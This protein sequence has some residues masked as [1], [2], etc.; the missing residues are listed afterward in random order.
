MDLMEC[1]A[2]FCG[3]DDPVTL[4]EGCCPVCP[5]GLPWSDWLISLLHDDI[6]EP[7]N[8]TD[9][10][11]LHNETWAT[12]DCEQCMCTNGRVN[13]SLPNTPSESC[14]PVDECDN[15]VIV[16]NFDTM[17]CPVCKRS[18]CYYFKYVHTYVCSGSLCIDQSSVII[19]CIHV[20]T[21]RGLVS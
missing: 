11:R 4:V 14:V 5:T 10:V 12:E 17:C 21:K 3:D 18:E 19:L 7:C 6:I 9:V 1:P 13:C 15:G 16:I 2:L 20:Q 8:T